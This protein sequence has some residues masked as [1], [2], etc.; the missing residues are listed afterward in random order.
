MYAYDARRPQDMR[1]RVR[2]DWFHTGDLA[3]ID[4]E[5]YVLIVDRAKDMI[6]TGGENVASAEIERVIYGHPSV[7]ECAVI[8]VPDDRWGEV[9]KAIIALKTGVPASETDILAHCRQHLGGFK[10]PKS[11]EFIDALPKGG[12][13]KILKKVLREKFWAGRDRRVS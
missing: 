2:D 11:V 13:G 7:L 1:S 4:E 10:V 12:T 8:A 5:G 3:T 9:P 6:L